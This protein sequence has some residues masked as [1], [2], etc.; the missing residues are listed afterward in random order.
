[1]REILV[2]DQIRHCTIPHACIFTPS[3]YT[4]SES[5]HHKL[6]NERSLA[7]IWKSNFLP[8]YL[9]FLG[10]GI[11]AKSQGRYPKS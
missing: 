5:T 11:D 7:Y 10:L 8:V 6:S 1:M 3:F 2:F 9:P 4:D